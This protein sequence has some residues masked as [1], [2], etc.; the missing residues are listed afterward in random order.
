M[1]GTVY[2]IPKSFPLLGVALTDSPMGLASYILEKFVTFTDRKLV[3]KEYAGLRNSYSYE[4][5]LDNI[6]IYWITGSITSSM[7]LYAE[8]FNPAHFALGWLRYL[9]VIIHYNNINFTS[10]GQTTSTVLEQ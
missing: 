3:N 5:L 9:F 7:R 6:M 8:T 2:Y 10:I 4:S 1:D